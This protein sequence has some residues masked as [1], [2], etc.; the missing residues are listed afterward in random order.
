MWLGNG[1]VLDDFTALNKHL[2]KVHPALYF[3]LFDGIDSLAIT[4]VKPFEHQDEA[5]RF[6]AFVDRAYE[7]QVPMRCSGTPL[8]RIFPTEYL[9]GGY[10]KKYLRAISR[11]G[12]LT[13]L[14][15]A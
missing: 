9:E 13:A 15:R 8:T 6:V 12:A 7:A 1:G 5:L 11:L 10:A 2:A 14:E 3:H 4:D